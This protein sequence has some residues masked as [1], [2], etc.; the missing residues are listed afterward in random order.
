VKL[1]TKQMKAEYVM[2]HF[3]MRYEDSKNKKYLNA[4]KK[5]KVLDLA[6]CAHKEIDDAVN[7]DGWTKYCCSICGQLRHE[8]VRLF[9]GI[10]IVICS[11]CA[12][13][14][15]AMFNHEDKEE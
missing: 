1:L 2:S 7:H 12:D 9:D 6:S 14:I 13:D 4:V 8:V 11:N 15:K 5:L 10:N 3:N